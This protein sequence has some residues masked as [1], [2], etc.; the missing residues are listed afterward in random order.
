MVTYHKKIQEGRPKSA[1]W[2]KQIDALRR[3]IN[4]V[5]YLMYHKNQIA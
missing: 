1:I 2:F 4:K 3:F 5:S